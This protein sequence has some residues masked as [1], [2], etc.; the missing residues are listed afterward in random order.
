MISKR[1]TYN[2][3]VPLEYHKAICKVSEKSESYVR[4]WSE[5]FPTST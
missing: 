2:L 1:T 4:G 5:K 3:D